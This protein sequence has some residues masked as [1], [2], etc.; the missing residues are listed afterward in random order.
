MYYGVIKYVYY[1]WYRGVLFRSVSKLLPGVCFFV[2][3]RVV[4]TIPMYLHET[5][6]LLVYILI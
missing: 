3:Q 2:L 5:R 1:E 6:K 4:L